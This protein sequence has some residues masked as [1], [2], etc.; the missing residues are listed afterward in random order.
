MPFSSLTERLVSALEF[1][2]AR[3]ETALEGPG[4]QRWPPECVL[5]V[6]REIR[7]RAAEALA[8]VDQQAGS[9]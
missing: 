1:I 7:D 8:D 9:N 6:V 2:E 5:T 3:A 4:Q